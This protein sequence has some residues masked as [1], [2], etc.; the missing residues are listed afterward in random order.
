LSK[1]ELA[2]SLEGAHRVLPQ[3]HHGR[4]GL[5]HAFGGQA[6]LRGS[7]NA[8]HGALH[9]KHLVRDDLAELIFGVIV[10]HRAPPR[11]S[12]ALNGASRSDC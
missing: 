11:P 5:Q 8:S 12:L 3:H 6:R 9:L 2:A 4:A 7:H 1:N 10:D